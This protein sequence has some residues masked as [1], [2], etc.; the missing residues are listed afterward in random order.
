MNVQL[1]TSENLRRERAIMNDMVSTEQACLRSLWRDLVGGA[2]VVVDRFFTIDRCYLIVAAS[3]RHEAGV[4]GRRLAI[5]EGILCGQGQKSI[6]I[7]LALAPSTIALNARLGLEAL[8]VAGKPSRVHPLLMLAA[9]VACATDDTRLATASA[10]EEGDQQ[11]RVFSVPRPDERLISL[12]P[13]AELAVVRHLVEG[14]CYQEIARLR[15]TSTRTIANQITAVF[16]RMR[17][18]GRNEL[19]QRL[20]QGEAL[21]PVPPPTLP[22]AP[23]Q[24]LVPPIIVAPRSPAVS[25][26][27]VRRYA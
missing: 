12:L 21:R 19:L 22:P 14:L 18:S 10:I 8:G 2:C 4:N 15:G 20:F 6:A 9:T 16:R 11:L 3:G 5:L 24:T 13:P 1:K 17:V 26:A 23:A 25:A 7:E 27:Q